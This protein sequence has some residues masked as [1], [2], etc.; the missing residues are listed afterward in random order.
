MFVIT[1]HKIHSTSNRDKPKDKARR[2]VS[3]QNKVLAKT[4]KKAKVTL[5]RT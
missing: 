4:V 2:E 5:S 1:I 3:T